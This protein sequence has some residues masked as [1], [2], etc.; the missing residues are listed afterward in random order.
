MKKSILFLLV[1]CFL[2]FG[3]SFITASLSIENVAGC[4]DMNATSGVVLDSVSGHDGV[5]F[6][7]TRGVN[8][9]IG[10]AFQFD[11]ASNNFVALNNFGISTSNFSISLWINATSYDQNAV[12]ATEN[13]INQRWQ[14]LL[15]GGGYGKFGFR[16]GTGTTLECGNGN[17]TTNA[18]NHI[19]AT[20]GGGVGTIYTNGNVCATGAM[21]APVHSTGNITLGRYESAYYYN[22]LM[23]VVLLANETY[24]S[25]VVNSLYNSGSGLGCTELVQSET[26]QVNLISPANEMVISSDVENFITNYTT[27][28]GTNLSNATLYIWR[29]NG[30]LFNNTE[31]SKITGQANQTNE[32]ISNLGLGS[33]DWNSLLWFDNSS[34]SFTKWATSNYSFS[35]GATIISQIN[36]NETY[37]TKNENFQVTIQLL[38]GAEISLAQLVYNGTNYSISNI[39]QSGNQ[40]TL[41]RNIDIPLND[42]T[43]TNQTNDFFYRFIYEGN[44]SQEI[45]NAEQNSAFINLQ[46]CDTTY[47]VRALNYT[48]TDETDLNPLNATANPIDFASTF[49][50]WLGTGSVYK[51]YSYSTLNNATNNQ[52]HFC[53]K[54]Y[55]EGMKTTTTTIYSADDYSEREYDLYNAS[56]SYQTSNITLF[57]LNDSASVKFTFTLK[58]GVTNVPDAYVTIS[59]FF[60]GEGIYKTTSIRNTDDSGQFVEYL[61]LDRDYRFSISKSNSLLGIID[62][63]ASCSTAPCEI[64]LQLSD[65]QG[66]IWTAYNDN[67]AANVYSNLTFNKSS[68]VVTYNF[69]DITGL[70]NYFRLE[71]S[72]SYLNESTENICNTFSYTSSGTITCNL[73]GY[74][75]DFV[76]KTYVS[77]SPEK[78]DKVLT[79][80][81]GEILESLGLLAVFI[82][83]FLIITMVFAGA[84]ISGGNPSVILFMFGFSLIA[85]KLM[86]ILPFSWGIV[87]LLELV[88]IWL[89]SQVKS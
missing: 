71:V 41:S 8:G 82:S 29:S 80:L 79:I 11:S 67:Y 14:L 16:L 47:S 31:F 88:T 75:G 9:I 58:Q 22:G 54:P 76:A 19:V 30:T 39:S 87:A 12:L 70:A 4:Y 78:L 65:A 20:Y 81:V 85:T 83:F 57:L 3:I 89:I 86:T 37:E 38:A 56:I 59:K 72:R 52:Y 34:G 44:F 49:Y 55:D 74:E 50:Y 51:N 62:K 25:S 53:L 7:A 45:G 48:L 27:P 40:Y 77:R 42:V 28:A 33:Y 61:E 21:S 36:N 2:L 68:R 10:N 84:A 26:P 17:L 13:P 15:N 6:G 43:L 35:V 32:T 64:T 1:L 66:N 46:T 23:D 60:V 18:W 5:N 69:V 73:T 63:R 24:D